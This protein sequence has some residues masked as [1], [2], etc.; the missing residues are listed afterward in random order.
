MPH[1]RESSNY[2]GNKTITGNLTTTGQLI[3][4]ANSA[5]SA[6]AGRF[7]G[8]WFSGGTT[9]TTTPHFLVADPTATETW[10]ASGTGIG[11]NSA[12][13]FTGNL[14][15]LRINGTERFGVTASGTTN[16]VAVIATGSLAAGA[17]STLG[18]TGRTL[19]RSASDGVLQLGNNGNTDFGRLQFGGTT[20]SFPSLKRS[21]T[22]LQARLADDS[23][24]T[25]IQGKHQVHANAAAETP[26]ATHT[27]R[28]FDAAGTE[29]KVLC[30]AA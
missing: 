21:T 28:M 11:V 16:L 6:P 24:Y 1:L 3:V 9:A 13:G 5:A 15:S 14:I 20:S 23:D 29:Y 4:S 19:L 12:N 8:T 2:I 7:T 10:S 22:I 30:V 25:F 27:L 26:T 17:S 18:F